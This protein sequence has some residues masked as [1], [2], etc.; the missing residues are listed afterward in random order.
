MRSG[1][2]VVICFAAKEGMDSKDSVILLD[3]LF[4]VFNLIPHKL[5][6]P[7]KKCLGA[8]LKLEKDKSNGL[9]RQRRLFLVNFLE[10]NYLSTLP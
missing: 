8:I 9:L 10:G 3:A 1:K 2:S 4:T 7:G 6:I 5:L